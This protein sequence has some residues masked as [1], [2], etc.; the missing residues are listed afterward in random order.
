MGVETNTIVACELWPYVVHPF[1]N[2]VV[3]LE[4]CNAHR[5][6]ELILC[7]SDERMRHVLRELRL[8]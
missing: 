5:G 2:P 8:R 3:C 6:R 7:V 1:V 4:Q